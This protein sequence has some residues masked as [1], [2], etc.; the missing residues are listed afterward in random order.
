LEVRTE[1]DQI[2]AEIAEGLNVDDRLTPVVRLEIIVLS[3]SQIP[4]PPPQNHPK[5]PFPFEIEISGPSDLL[6]TIAF[7]DVAMSIPVFNTM[8]SWG[9]AA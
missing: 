5:F 3:G 6:A 2:V 7:I 4:S 8:S 1:L 9:L